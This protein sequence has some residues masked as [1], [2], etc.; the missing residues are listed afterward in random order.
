MKDA[1]RPVPEEPGKLGSDPSVPHHGWIALPQSLAGEAL[2]RGS[3]QCPEWFLKGKR[4][5]DLAEPPREA[6]I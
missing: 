3:A 6:S 4:R 1:T 2:L 5:I